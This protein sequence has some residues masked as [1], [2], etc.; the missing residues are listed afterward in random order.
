MHIEE[1]HLFTAEEAQQRLKLLVD[2][3]ERKVGLVA[4]WDGSNVKVNGKAMGVTIQADIHVE[5]KRIVA[6]G[7]DPGLLFRSAAIGYIKRKFGEYFD[8]KVSL[9]DLAKH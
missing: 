7:A 1:A 4:K 9:A 6:E 3:W 5:A 2:S 8:P